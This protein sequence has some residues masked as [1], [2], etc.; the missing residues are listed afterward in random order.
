MQAKKYITAQKDKPF[1]LYFASQDIHVPRA[2]NKRFQGKTQLGHR[3]DAMVQFD[4]A[5]GEILNTLEALGLS[6][7]TIVIF[8]S[9]NGPVY[10]DGYDDGTTVQTSTKEMDGGH[11]GSGPF[12]GGKYQIYEG[13]T[14][15]PFIIRWPKKIT[16]GT[17]S[18]ALVN[19]I[20][21][22]ASFGALL[23]VPIAESEAAD[24]KNTLS[25][26]LGEDQAG[27]TYMLEE[28]RGG[29][30]IRK[31]DWKYIEPS[32][33]KKGQN[34]GELYNL[35][36]DIGEEKNVI[37]EFPEVAKELQEKITEIKNSK[38]QNTAIHYH[39]NQNQKMS[40]YFLY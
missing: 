5:T 37:N 39:R 16:A 21:L 2:P 18:K 35:A 8:S 32:K 3:G 30:A 11:D 38:Y 28:A 22:I 13:G 15:V 20:D 17:T 9:D 19:Q 25:A 7:N 33:N 4:W 40:L 14:R 24:S 23:N 31:A 10:D 12:R 29:L 26:F 27:L 6:E 34:K 1:F 36:N